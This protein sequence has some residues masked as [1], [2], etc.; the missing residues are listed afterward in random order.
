MFFFVVDL[1]VLEKI[2]DVKLFVVLI[3]ARFLRTRSRYFLIR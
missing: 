2:V 1:I 3:Y